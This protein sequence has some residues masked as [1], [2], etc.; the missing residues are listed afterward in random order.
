MIT[1]IYKIT[2]TITNDFYIGQ[3]KNIKKRFYNHRC[4]KH[5]S[6]PKLHDDIEKYGIENFRLDV[7]EECSIEELRTKELQYIHELNPQYNVLGKPRPKETREKLS[8][9]NLGKKQSEETKQ[10]RRISI[11]ERHKIFP[12]LNEG[13][14]KQ[15]IVNEKD[16]YPSVKECAY[17]LQVTPSHISHSIKL[18]GKVKG[19]VVR[20]LKCR[21]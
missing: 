7:L 20:Y 6:N 10:K 1:G 4:K 16:I 12:Q 3:A 2:N 21:D 9:A 15:V 19:N 17:A 8:K 5:Y 18:N 11:A 13:H 14:K